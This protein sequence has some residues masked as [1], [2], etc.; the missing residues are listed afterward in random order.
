MELRFK[1]SGYA[2]NYPT[3]NGI[4]RVRGNSLVLSKFDNIMQTI[5]LYSTQT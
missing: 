5:I 1:F 2:K 3:A 4:S